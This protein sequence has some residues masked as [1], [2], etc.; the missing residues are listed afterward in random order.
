MFWK[1]VERDLYLLFVSDQIFVLMLEY[2]AEIN[3]LKPYVG[4][5]MGLISLVFYVLSDECADQ[6][7][8]VERPLV[9]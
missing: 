3:V 2:P 1:F 5:G 8:S 7:S 6:A 4:V 9:N